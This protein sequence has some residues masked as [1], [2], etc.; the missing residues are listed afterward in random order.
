MNIWGLVLLTTGLPQT[1]GNLKEVR[2]AYFASMLS[3]QEMEKFEHL[4][5]L[6]NDDSS[7]VMI[8][9]RGVANLF[10]AKETANPISKF[11]FFSRGKKLIELGLSKDSA[12]IEC[13]FLRY[14]IQR[15]L[16]HFLHYDQ[17]LASDKKFIEVAVDNL[18]D[19]DLKENIV[20]YLN[21]ERS[22]AKL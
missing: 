12:N 19:D 1:A 8:C 20:A 18:K 3:K 7:P 11:S 21:L 4:A 10:K 5:G 14:T 9:Y 13:R 6:V 15:N 16:P 22:N 17:N 2:Q